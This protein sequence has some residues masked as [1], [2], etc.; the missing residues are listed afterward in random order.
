MFYRLSVLCLAAFFT[1]PLFS[2]S[3]SEM[4]MKD[5]QKKIKQIKNDL[6]SVVSTKTPY[7]GTISDYFDKSANGYGWYQENKKLSW[8]AG[9]SGAPLIGS[10][11]R[12]L[13][14]STG[15]GT[16]GVM[17]GDWTG[18]ELLSDTLKIYDES[19]YWYAPGGRYPYSCGFINGFYFSTFN[20]FDGVTA[21]NSYPMFSVVNATWGYDST[22]STVGVVE[23]SFGGRIPGAWCGTGDVVYDPGTGFYYW[24][25]A[26]N[27]DLLAMEDFIISSVVGRSMTPSDSSSWDW[28]NHQEL[29]FDCSDDTNGL[30]QMNQLQFAYCKDVYGNGTGYGIA[31]CMANDVGDRIFLDSMDIEY[32]PRISYMYTTD[33]GGDDNTI[34]WSS[35]WITDGNKL[36]RIEPEDLFDWYG[37]TFTE[38]D[39]VSGD[40]IKTVLND[41]FITWNISAVATEYNAVHLLIKVFGG[42]TEPG[43]ADDL[44][45]MNDEDFIAGY[46]HVRGLI[47]DTGVVWSPAH[48]VAS[49]IGLDTGEIEYVWSNFNI[50]S[51]GYAGFGQ[52][53]G[54]WLDRPNT[55]PEI[56]ED[57][58]PDTVYIDDGFLSFSCD[59]GDTW[60]IP[61]SDEASDYGHHEVYFDEDSLNVYNLYY[62]MN[63]TK[64]STLHESGWVCSSNGKIE[65]G[66]IEVY[67]ACQYYD[68][69]AVIPPIFGQI[70]FQQF[71][72]VWKI[73]GSISDGT[74]IS[75]EQ[76]SLMNDFELMQNYP[77]PFNPSTEISFKIQNDSKVKLTVFNSNGEKVASL[78]DSK[79]IKG[80]HRVNF[81]ATHLNSGIY[82]YTLEVNERSESKKMILI[83]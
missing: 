20:D 25:Q 71:L 13:N 7:E 2:I 62:P 43:K 64:T 14:P 78:V 77:N 32:N 21:T 68:Y 45:Y 18:E 6:S 44:Y 5:G 53:Y 36:F 37:T 54:T 19:N 70:N 33:W 17:V 42:T 82:F 49:L 30:I 76:V 1:V 51:I 57:P 55:R 63:V 79:M 81:D 27:Q 23:D 75:A 28:T 39:S 40:T 67:T 22:I 11:Y 59:D 4:K 48:F 16:M 69:V 46:Y 24:S 35:N 47:T 66:E 74:G 61:S 52:I 29:T 38:I 10:I 15:S 72:H 58:E 9:S 3:K 60:E 50:L 12:K 65:S 83:K 56:N 26:W 31:V 41:P 8:D 34:N 73:T 80:L